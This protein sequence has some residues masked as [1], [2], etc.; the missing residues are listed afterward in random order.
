MN[1]VYAA[2]ELGKS[3]ANPVLLS[4]I[5][6][7]KRTAQVHP[8]RVATVNELRDRARLVSWIAACQANEYYFK[9]E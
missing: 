6:K 9:E 4:P 3:P 2:L 1:P 7:L 8:D 5:S